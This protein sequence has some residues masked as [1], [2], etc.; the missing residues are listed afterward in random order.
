MF[1]CEELSLFF[2]SSA[3]NHAIIISV[4]I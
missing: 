1:F 3:T 2:S 4:L